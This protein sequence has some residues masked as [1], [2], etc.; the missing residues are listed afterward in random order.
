M[1]KSR[2]CM[3]LFCFFSVFALIS[4]SAN[5]AEL[6]TAAQESS[7]RYMTSEVNGKKEIHGLCIDIMRAIERVDPDIKFVGDQQYAPFARIKS[8]LEKGELDVFVGF[9]K[10]PER[11]KSYVFIDPSLYAINHVVAVR[12]DDPVD[13]KSFDDIRK[14]G[15]D[16]RI[17][18]VFGIWTTDFLKAQK[19][20][21]IDESGKTVDMNLDKLLANRGRFFYYHDLGIYGTIKQPQYSGKVKVL[22]TSFATDYQY[23]A[24]SKK[25]PRETIEKV[26]AALK[27]LNDSG[28]L[29]KLYEKYKSGI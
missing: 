12:A 16:G 6:K 23:I 25:T 1:K 13:V 14:L 5:A 24:F 26:K 10:T 19:D 18:T 21:V 8:E 3:A 27:K 2:L 28:D 4:P 15:V 9:V 7:P 20:L 17:L 29:K 11:E 22:P